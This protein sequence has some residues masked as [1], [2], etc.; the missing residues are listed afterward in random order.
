MGRRVTP[1]LGLLLILLLAVITGLVAS[2]RYFQDRT[3]V[4][5]SR[6][7]KIVRNIERIHTYDEILTGSARLAAATGDH[8]YERRYNHAAP[9]LDAVIA[10]TLELVSNPRA[11]A[12]IAETSDANQALIKMERRSFALGRQGHGRE[13]SALLTSTEYARQKDIYSQGSKRAASIFR[14]TVADNAAQVRRYRSTALGI[15]IFG[16]AIL[17]LAS[18]ILLRLARERERIAAEH[19]NRTLIEGERRLAEV[20]YFESQHHFTDILQITRR[21]SEAHS[22][23]KR[24]LERTIPGGVVAV[25]NRNDVENRLD[26]VTPLPEGSA[27]FAALEGAEPGA[28]AAVRLGRTHER[29]PDGM[30]LLECELCGKLPGPSLCAPSL[31]GGEVIGSVLV[32]CRDRITEDVR[33]RVEQTVAQAAPVLINL[34]NLSDAEER[35][36]TDNLTGLPNKRSIEE[37]LKRMAAQASRS[38]TVLAAIMLDLDHFKRV[39]DV[40]GHARG[41][42]VLTAVGA[43][44]TGALRESDY[45]GRYGGEEFLILLPDTTR[46]GALITAARLLSAIANL[47]IATEELSI[48]AS[49]GVALMPDDADTSEDLFRLADRALY[50]AKQAGRNRIECAHSGTV[51]FD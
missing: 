16:G 7:E 17:L 49:L 35:A 4:L 48:T 43:A 5:H 21:E 44:I 28:C 33:R 22:L 19:D 3:L 23:I 40:Y 6:A 13:A 25:V 14:A 42:E 24:H 26:V 34:R 2:N 9:E 38:A 45:A 46:D 51:V 10:E 37:T 39:N 15:G 18:I 31:V 29:E 36:V 32:E 20:E 50:A 12:A 27:M 47:R 8:A 30:S 41:D 1:Q 11:E